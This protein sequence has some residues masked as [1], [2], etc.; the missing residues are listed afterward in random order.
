MSKY[1]IQYR[2]DVP[3]G[4]VRL[5]GGRLKKS[6]DDN[7]AFLKGFDLDRILYWYR[8]HAGKPV[9]GVPYAADA[10]HFE[11]NLKGQTAGQFMMGAGTALLW[12]EDEELRRTIDAILDEI[13]AVQWISAKAASGDRQAL[14]DVI[15]TDP[16]LAGLDRL[17]CLDVVEA[18]IRLNE[19]VLDRF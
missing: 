4:G 11:N 13:A 10:G 16:A 3:T 12:Q 19:S 8:V 14:R 1:S 5:T 7:I 9:P 2:A 18:L 17:Y 6:F 15:E